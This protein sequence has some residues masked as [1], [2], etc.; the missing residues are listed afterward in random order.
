MVWHGREIDST[1][2][3][4]AADALAAFEAAQEARKST[5]DCYR[6]GV[7]AWRR[8]HPDQTRMYAAQRAVAVIL[9]AKT[10]LHI[11]DE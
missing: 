4:A 8:V 6:A 10:S 3:P 9:A 5:A 11:P 1:T 7:E 2:D